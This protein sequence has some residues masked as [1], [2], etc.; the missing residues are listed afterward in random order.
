MWTPSDFEGQLKNK[1]ATIMWKEIKS[2]P[3]TPEVIWLKSLYYI[4]QKMKKL[5]HNHKK[6]IKNFA[7][8][9]ESGLDCDLEA[10][11]SKLKAKGSR[12]L[13]Q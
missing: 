6:K 1:V 5:G 7:E 2:Q 9:F 12:F 4:H 11:R 13:A 10:E 3:P 8:F